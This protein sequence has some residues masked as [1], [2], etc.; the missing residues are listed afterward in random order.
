MGRRRDLD[1]PFIGEHQGLRNCLTGKRI[2]DLLEP[3]SMKAQCT[4]QPVDYLDGSLHHR[5]KTTFVK[6]IT[7]DIRFDVAKHE[8]DL[9]ILSIA[10][11]PHARDEFLHSTFLDMQT[12][13]RRLDSLLYA[14]GE[15]Y[16][17]YKINNHNL[18]Q[19]LAK[20]VDR[21]QALE[22]RIEALEKELKE[23]EDIKQMLVG[24]LLASRVSNS[25]KRDALERQ[26][27]TI[28]TQRRHLDN[29]R[30]ENMNIRNDL[31]ALLNKYTV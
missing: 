13:R 3:V 28:E 11:D 8:R 31:Q 29:E 18:S 7:V 30:A 21:R 12:G 19:E 1:A 2:D 6:G 22:L 24:Q 14:I 10:R 20:E 26:K 17:E 25:K 23:S 27:T 16:H 5:K 9:L 4:Y 15:M